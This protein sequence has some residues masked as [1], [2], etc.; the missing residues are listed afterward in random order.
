MQ[1]QLQRIERPVGQNASVFGRE[2]KRLGK[3][4]YPNGNEEALVASYIRGLNE[5]HLRKYVQL[6][7]PSSLDEAIEHACIFQTVEGE[8]DSGSSSKKPKLVAPVKAAEPSKP[9]WEDRLSSLETALQE[10]VQRL[11]RPPQRVPFDQVECFYCHEKGHY[12]SS[13]PRKRQRNAAT[14][15]ALASGESQHSVTAGPQY[16]M[17]ATP[18]Y[19]MA[20]SPQYPVVATPQYPMAASPQY[21]LVAT[22]QYPMAASPQYPMVAPSQYSVAGS[23]PYPETTNSLNR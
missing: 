20:A 17:V 9:A 4:A 19:P 10:V 21:P 3:K 12:S 2:I 23:D 1:A 22:P 13:C 16:P 5:E 8:F 11:D 6:K 18:Q 14:R 15:V 7:M